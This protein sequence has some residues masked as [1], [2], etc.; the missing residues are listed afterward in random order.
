MPLAGPSPSCW[1]VFVQMEHCDQLLTEKLS[2]KQR[3]ARYGN[4]LILM[5]AKFGA[6]LRKYW[7][8]KLIIV[9]VM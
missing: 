2:N 8:G 7:Q 9:W 6:K 1:A 4:I 3:V 5:I